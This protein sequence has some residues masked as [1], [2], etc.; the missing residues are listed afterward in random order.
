MILK[1]FQKEHSM[2]FN[3]QLILTDH[4]LNL[5]VILTLIKRFKALPNTSRENGH[6]GLHRIRMSLFSIAYDRRLFGFMQRIMFKISGRMV[7][8]FSLL[9]R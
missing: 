5:F 2:N 9:I 7:S 1:D 6:S 4:Y 3:K 8:Q